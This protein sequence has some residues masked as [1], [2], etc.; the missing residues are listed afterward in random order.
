MN[1]SDIDIEL[2]LFG[3]W[4]FNTEWEKISIEFKDDMTYTQTRTQTFIL[5]KPRELFTGDKFSGV[6]YV[7]YGRLFLIVKSAPQSVFNFHLPILSKVY[8]ADAIASLMSLFVS[9]KYEI[10]KINPTE[11]LLKDEKQSIIG[12]RIIKKS[13]FSSL[14]S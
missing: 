7:N 2:L 4:R 8:L 12:K 3:K 1:L 10:V 5:S 9:E 11:F 6:W 14:Q 13:S